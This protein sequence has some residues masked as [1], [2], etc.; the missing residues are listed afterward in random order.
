MFYTVNHQ[1]QEYQERIRQAKFESQSVDGALTVVRKKH[2]QVQIEEKWLQM[3]QRI[4]LEQEKKTR[5]EFEAL[6]KELVR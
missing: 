4:L 2:V 3:R 6:K 5:D 1:I